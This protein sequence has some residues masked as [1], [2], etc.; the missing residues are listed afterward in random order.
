M[1]MRQV[2][3]GTLAWAGLV[4]VVAV[5]SA[6][7][8]LSRLTHATSAPVPQSADLAVATAPVPI[9][10]KP[11]EAVPGPAMAP[12][13]KQASVAMPASGAAPVVESDSSLSAKPQIE[14]N[15]YFRWIAGGRTDEDRA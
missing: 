6:E 14:A 1:E 3:T 7:A 4:V 8:L 10:R 9:A 13:I 5:P 2:V 11:A 15:A 12:V